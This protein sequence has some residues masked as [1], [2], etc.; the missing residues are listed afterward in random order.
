MAVADA[1]M[2]LPWDLLEES[3]GYL[4]K[5]AHVTARCGGICMVMTSEVAEV[6]SPF[7]V[8]FESQ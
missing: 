5:I 4:G 7:G 3:A 2:E 6:S 8:S 1:S